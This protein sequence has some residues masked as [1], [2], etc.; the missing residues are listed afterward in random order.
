MKETSSSDKA[1]EEEMKQTKMRKKAKKQPEA[2][3]LRRS[4][5]ATLDRPKAA[6]MN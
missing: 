6:Y 1:K 3:I 5:S 2:C 4:C